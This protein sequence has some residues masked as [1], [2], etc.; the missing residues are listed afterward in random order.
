M[1][2]AAAVDLYYDV[3]NPDGAFRPGQRLTAHLRLKSSR[4][5][6]TLP[7]SAVIHDIYGGQWVFEQV[8]PEKFVRRRVDVEWVQDGMAVLARGPAAGTVVVTAGA[9]ELAGTEFGFSK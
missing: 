6:D 1:P 7:W 9:A 3:A 8:E 4:E 2:L 5:Q